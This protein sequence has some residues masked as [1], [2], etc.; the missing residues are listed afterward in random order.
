MFFLSVVLRTNL[1]LMRPVRPTRWFRLR[2]LRPN[3]TLKGVTH[4]V[5]NAHALRELQA[6]IEYERELWAFD[7]K[8]TLHDALKLTNVVRSQGRDAVAPE[9]IKDIERRFGACCKQVDTSHENQP[10]FTPRRDERSEVDRNGAS[11][12]ISHCD[13]GLR[14]KLFYSFFTTLMCRSQMTRQSGV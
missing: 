11:G 1:L 2:D 13:S 4:R 10:P 5:G 12:T 9:T 3:W 14:T 6:L 8:T 7:M